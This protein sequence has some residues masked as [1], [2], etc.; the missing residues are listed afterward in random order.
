MNTN[1]ENFENFEIALT[2]DVTLHLHLN[3]CSFY[4]WCPV[5]RKTENCPLVWSAHKSRKDFYTLPLPG[6]GPH[7]NL[8]SV[9]GCTLDASG[10]HCWWRKIWSSLM[11]QDIGN[12]TKVEKEEEE[13]KKPRLAKDHELPWWWPFDILKI[14]ISLYAL[15]HHF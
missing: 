15:G 9:G 2:Q 4:S 6:D 7:K 8:D 1:F 12:V 14:M 10:N 13:E 11:I 5:D 3:P